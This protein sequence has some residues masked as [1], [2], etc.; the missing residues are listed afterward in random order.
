MAQD[1]NQQEPDKYYRYL[2]GD[3]KIHE[4]EIKNDMNDDD[5]KNKN[6]HEKNNKKDFNEN[7]DECKFTIFAAIDKSKDQDRDKD[8]K[9]EKN[10]E[11][12]WKILKLNQILNVN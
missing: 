1:E 9:D 8:N 12:K 10:G 2:G 4:I 5:G 7:N 6:N 3:G 11:I